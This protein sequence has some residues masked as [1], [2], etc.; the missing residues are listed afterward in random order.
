MN[1]GSGEVESP[2]RSP[3]PGNITTL[4]SQHSPIFTQV[5]LTRASLEI[6]WQSAEGYLQKFISEYPKIGDIW[7]FKLFYLNPQLAAGVW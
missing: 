1:T 7:I 5:P 2:T 6:L 4:V 3:A